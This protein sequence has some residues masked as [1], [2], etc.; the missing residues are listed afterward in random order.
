MS[1]AAQMD[2]YRL[3]KLERTRDYEALKGLKM[4]DCTACSGSGHYDHGGSPACSSCGGRGKV[5]ERRVPHGR[6]AVDA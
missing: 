3:R 4:V 2:G 1:G 5:R 6:T